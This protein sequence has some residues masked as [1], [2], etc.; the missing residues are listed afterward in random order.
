MGWLLKTLGGG[1]GPYIAGGVAAVI[2]A[3]CAG[4][5][6]QTMRL[7]H[8]KADLT[9]ARSDLKAARTA[10]DGARTAIRARDDQ[11]RANADRAA[12]EATELADT[13]RLTCKGAFNAGYA[14]RRCSDPG[15]ADGGVLP[16]LRQAQ[17]V[18]AYRSAAGDV[19]A[20]PAGGRRR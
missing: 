5:G 6:V 4:V 3:L 9:S 2:L 14:S 11:I 10:L 7:N 13:L 16:D 19:P 17:L 15:A 12:A 8:T 1:L 18:G 20:E